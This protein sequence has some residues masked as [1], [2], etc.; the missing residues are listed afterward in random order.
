MTGGERPDVL[1]LS[2]FAVAAGTDGDGV[3]LSHGL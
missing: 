1:T 2:V 3:E